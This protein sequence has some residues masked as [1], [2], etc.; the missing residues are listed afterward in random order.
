MSF[1]A[2]LITA[3]IALLVYRSSAK[4]PDQRNQMMIRSIAL[5]IG[6]LAVLSAAWRNLTIIPAGNVGVLE[7]FGQIDPQPLQ[8][9]IH[10]THPFADIT[11]FSTRLRD[12][13]ETIEATSQEGLAFN[14]D[15]SL[16]YR[17]QPEKA[18]EVYQT[19]GSDESEIV[20]SRFRSTVREVTASYPAVA[21]YSSRRQEVAQKLRDRL[22]QQLNPLGFKIEE[23]LLREVILPESLQVAVQEKLQAEQE[24]QQ[25]T[26][27][28]A[29]ERQ[30]A[31]RKRIEAKGTAD[32][33]RILAEGTSERSLQL[34]T[35]EATEKLA[36]SENA[37]IVILGG[38][39]TL[40]MTLQ[41]NANPSNTP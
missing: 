26:F 8:P 7:S 18:T 32:A 19:I 23:A 27:T 11:Q 31:E 15:V 1:I 21:I 37:K 10:L 30:E 20:V 17:L 13:K 29:K 4:V 28:L 35:I 16:Q 3:L 5:L 25:M 36:A 33:Q 6:G 14:L 2:S 9:G 34:R 38:S 12:V 24:S 41:L 22:N 40:P 39:G